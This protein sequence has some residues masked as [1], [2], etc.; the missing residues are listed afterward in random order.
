MLVRPITFENESLTTTK[1]GYRRPHIAYQWCLNIMKPADRI[2]A[3]GFGR[4]NSK[5]VS[6]VPI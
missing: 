4:N 1:A 6:D 5:Q 2:S 3:H